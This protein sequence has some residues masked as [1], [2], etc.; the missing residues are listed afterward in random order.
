MKRSGMRGHTRRGISRISLRSIRA[1][2][3]RRLVERHHGYNFDAVTESEAC[4]VL[5]FRT[6]DAVRNRIAAAE[7]ERYGRGGSESGGFEEAGANEIT[8]SGATCGREYSRIS[9]HSIRAT[10]YSLRSNHPTRFG[11]LHH[12]SL[13]AAP[14]NISAMRA[15][16]ARLVSSGNASGA[17]KPCSTISCVATGAAVW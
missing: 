9:L 14:P 10:R 2:L 1:M 5:R 17:K 6:A 4:A 8:G 12:N 7:Q 3:A 13:T 11:E 16:V 15:R